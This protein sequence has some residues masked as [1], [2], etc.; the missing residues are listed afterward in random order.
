MNTQGAAS[1][2]SGEMLAV[3][4]ASGLAS[5][6]LATASA[7]PQLGEFD[8]L[9]RRPS[10]SSPYMDYVA[11]SMPDKPE[12]GIP[13]MLSNFGGGSSSN[14]YAPEG[15]GPGDSLGALGGARAS[16]AAA[17]AGTSIPFRRTASEATLPR[18][19]SH[20]SIMSTSSFDGILGPGTGV[21]SSSSSSSSTAAAAATTSTSARTHVHAHQSYAPPTAATSSALYSSSAAA[22]ASGTATAASMATTTAPPS[23]S[24]GFRYAPSQAPAGYGGT[25]TMA[26]GSPMRGPAHYVAGGAAAS[27]GYQ[28]QH[29]PHQQQQQQQHHHHH[30]HYPG[31][32]PTSS[33][34][35]APGMMAA[36]TSP[37]PVPHA[38]PA[39]TP[40][41]Q[42]QPQ[43]AAYQA[44]VAHPGMM[45]HQQQQ[46]QQA[47][48]MPQ[49]HHA[50]PGYGPA[51]QMPA[52]PPMAP[53]T[54]ASGS[55]YANS[56]HRSPMRAHAP[57]PGFAA[58]RW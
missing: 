34:M 51:T 49:H 22:A 37:M 17:S 9:A 46:Q 3:P 21:S 2:M 35:P 45:Y 11:E 31:T 40:Q 18:M 23:A 1:T 27:G 28:H 50:V 33:G 54:A 24:S 12:P 13:G 15:G 55:P 7:P 57:P 8:Q 48:L 29:S 26:G 53:P 43:H 5:N 38:P 58:P 39:G 10:Q 30:H 14:V 36:Y 41:P 4:R 6:R 16:A 42:H 47:Q 25:P 32:A 52:Q 20:A 19:M 44:P 56:T